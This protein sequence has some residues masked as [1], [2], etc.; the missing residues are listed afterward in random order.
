MKAKPENTDANVGLAL[1]RAGATPECG[2]SGER[3][4]HTARTALTKAA[5]GVMA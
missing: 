5:P 4:D 1:D 2:S 3:P